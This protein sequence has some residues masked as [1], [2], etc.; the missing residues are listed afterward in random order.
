MTEQQLNAGA[1]LIELGSFVAI[2]S[3]AVHS[4]GLRSRLIVLLGAVAPLLCAYAYVTARY[5]AFPGTEYDWSF[6]AM[7]LMSFWP[8]IG[9]VVIGVFLSF[10]KM[11]INLAARF[12]MG[13][14]A[15]VSVWLLIQAGV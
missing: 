2:L 15:P 3:V 4:P 13:L 14:A 7:W 6:G 8:Y 9:C 12:L 1:I 10:L 5:V 11:P